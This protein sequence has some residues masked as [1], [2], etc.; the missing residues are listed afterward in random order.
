MIDR[1]NNRDDFLCSFNNVVGIEAGY[2]ANPDDSGNWTGG[3]IGMG[4]CKG[5]KFGISAAQYP[6]L[7][8]VNLTMSQATSIYRRDYWDVMHCD[9]LPWPLKLYAFDCAV[10]QGCD[11]KANFRAQRLLQRALGIDADGIIGFHTLKAASTSTPWHAARYMMLRVR[12]Y[13]DVPSFP[14][15]GDGWLIRLFQ[16]ARLGGQWE[17]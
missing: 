17:F 1:V 10:N 3:R 5:T 11:A 7:D 16:I 12:A 8:I 14:A 2:T 6:D 4:V 9:S 15:F 13:M